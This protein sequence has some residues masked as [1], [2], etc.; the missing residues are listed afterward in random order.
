[1]HPR[2][3]IVKEASWTVSNITAGNV[4]QIQQIIDCGVI[5]PLI[6]VL[7]TVSINLKF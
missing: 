3:N 6:K 2:S 4:D 5:Q 7:D 1:M